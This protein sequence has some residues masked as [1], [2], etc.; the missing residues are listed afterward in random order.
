MHPYELI[1][2]KNP[3]GFDQL[4]S[5]IKQRIAEVEKYI[6][7]FA[8]E[9]GQP[10]LA[11]KDTLYELF[12]RGVRENLVYGLREIFTH[13]YYIFKKQI[14]NE[15][16]GIHQFDERDTEILQYFHDKFKFPK[17]CIR[18]VP[19][20]GPSHLVFET[21]FSMSTGMYIIRYVNFY[22]KPIGYAYDALI[23]AYGGSTQGAN[24]SIDVQTLFDLDVKGNVLIRPAQLKAF[25]TDENFWIRSHSEVKSERCRIAQASSVEKKL[26]NKRDYYNRKKQDE[27]IRLS[28]DGKQLWVSRDDLIIA[29]FEHQRNPIRYVLRSRATEDQISYYETHKEELDRAK[30]E[31]VRSTA[32]KRWGK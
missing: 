23:R 12:Q 25:N 27:R 6:V 20:K 21:T 16:V 7:S 10:E 4:V 1:K 3:V 18:H 2:S 8:D 11:D 15:M 24:P 29:L 17:N 28:V 19:T 30:E 9:A 22:Y 5:D 32:Q 13:Y 14:L 26:K 31:L